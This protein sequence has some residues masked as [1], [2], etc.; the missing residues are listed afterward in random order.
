[1]S[2]QWWIYVH[3]AGVFGLLASHGVSMGVALRLRKERDP[4]RVVTL[5]E[6]SS[7]SVKPFYVSLLVLLAGGI[8]ATT[9]AKLW[10][11][12]WIHMSIGT[13]VAVSVAMLIVARPYYRKVAFV[14]RAM[15]G[16][17]QAVTS[18]EFEAVLRSWRGTAVVAMGV[19]ALGGILHLMLFKPT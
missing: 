2:Y 10:S 19:V 14:A 16:G 13:L 9:V 5:L 15:A 7:L 6:L 12:P 3:L 17:S 8:G 1:M 11:A 4:A 18:Q